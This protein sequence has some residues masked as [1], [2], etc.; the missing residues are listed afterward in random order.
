MMSIPSNM[1]A[2]GQG[3][4]VAT[5]AKTPHLANTLISDAHRFPLSN[6]GPRTG[7]T[8]AYDVWL[9][10]I[11]LLLQAFGVD[12]DECPVGI[13]NVSIGCKLRE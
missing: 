3:F 7:R 9:R 10:G 12:P 6:W 8:R 4:A 1:V 2:E 5:P 13:T 11:Q